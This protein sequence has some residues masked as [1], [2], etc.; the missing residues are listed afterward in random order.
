MVWVLALIVI[1]LF[2]FLNRWN[3]TVSTD[4]EDV[5]MTVASSH[6]QGLEWEPGRH[7]APH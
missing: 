3:E 6:L 1:A 5:P 7:R 2:G 4:L